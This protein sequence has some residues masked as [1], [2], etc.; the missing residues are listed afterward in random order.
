LADDENARA[1]VVGEAVV[2]NESGV[3][4]SQQMLASPASYGAFPVR[5]LFIAKGRLQHGQR[6]FPKT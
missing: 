3:A 5:V 1:K 4:A 2:M 6:G